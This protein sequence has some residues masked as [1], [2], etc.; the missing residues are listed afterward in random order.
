[1]TLYDISVPIENA[2]ATWPG[3]PPVEVE[4]RMD[5]HAGDPATVSNLNAGV[6][7]GTHVD[8]FSHFLKD[9]KTLSEMPLEPYIGK[10]LVIQVQNP[11][12]IPL[13][14][15]HRYD[16]S[17]YERILFKTVNSDSLWSQ[18]PFN[19][20]FCHLQPQ[21]AEHL[22]KMGVKLVGIDY[23]SVEGYHA[24]TLYKEHYPQP[25]ATHHILLNAGVYILEGLYLADV[26]PGEYELLA[27]P[28]KIAGADGAPARAV[29][30][31]LT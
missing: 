10:A 1:M 30:R 29:L 22:V 6:H 17:G 28:L 5:V 16:L 2:M 8:A 15:L 25:A 3:D 21:A 12:S 7:T 14:E 4:K 23:L 27:L 18:K 11:A 24:D 19:E 9:G 26:P 20:H 13:S 31:T